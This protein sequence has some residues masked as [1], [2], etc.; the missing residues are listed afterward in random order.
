MTAIATSRPDRATR[1]AIADPSRINGDVPLRKSDRAAYIAF[2]TARNAENVRRSR[3][4]RVRVARCPAPIVP[5]SVAATPS[6]LAMHAF[7]EWAA[8]EAAAAL[9]GL[10][11]TVLDIGCGTGT[12]TMDHLT[13]AGL[14]GR[15]IGLDIARHPKWSDQSRGGFTPSLVLGQAETADLARALGPSRSIDLVISSTALEHIEHVTTALDRV[16]S[17]LAPHAWQIHFVPGTRSLPLYG[18]HGWRQFS[19]RCLHDLFPSGEIFSFLGPISDWWHR[20]FV[21]PDTVNASINR[22]AR[23]RKTYVLGRTLAWF[24]DNALS[25]AGHSDDLDATMFGVVVRP[26]EGP[27]HTIA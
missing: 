8:G 18:P 15:Y 12:V 2:H 11:I 23:Y 13:S 25:Q 7:F 24:V 1:A 22:R 21:T 6:R 3:E 9:R 27:T 17:F 5:V 14:R 10:D 4:E 19:P 16:A 20:L 26:G